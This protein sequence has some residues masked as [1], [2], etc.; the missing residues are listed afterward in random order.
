[1]HTH[2]SFHRLTISFGSECH[3][4]EWEKK[5]PHPRYEFG[6]NFKL[7][8]QDL[9]SGAIIIT[10]EDKEGEWKIEVLLFLCSIEEEFL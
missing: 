10:A 5:D 4:S 3:I 8:N 9:E 7:S 6:A 1:M 2:T